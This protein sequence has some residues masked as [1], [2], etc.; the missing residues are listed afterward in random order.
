MTAYGN[1]FKNKAAEK[2]FSSNYAKKWKYPEAVKTKLQ[3]IE[4]F[5]RQ[6]KSLNDVVNYPPFHLHQLLGDRNKEWS[7]YVGNTGYRVSLF[8]CDDY[9][10]PITCGDII[11]KSTSI[12]N[13]VV[14]EVS[15]HY[16]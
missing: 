7:I 11:A 5:I 12:N 9:G 2:Q 4:T 15:N 3:G 13:I 14:I 16:E 10:N 6:A 1:F 8:P